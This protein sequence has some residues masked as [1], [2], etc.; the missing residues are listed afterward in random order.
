[1]AQNFRTLRASRKPLK[2]GDVFVMGLPDAMHLFG[3]VIS[4]S[5]RWT[6]AQDSGTT[7]LV[8]VFDHRSPDRAIPAREHLRA[9]RLLVPPQLV[10]RL[11]WNRGY[12]E[13]LGTLPFEDGET[14]DVHCFESRTFAAGP[15][16]F[17]DTARELPRPVPPVGV[18]GAGNHRTLEDAACEALGIPLAPDD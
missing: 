6:V 11:G 10:N 15:R 2:P 16:W 8:Y 9:D 18:W 1:M 12:F 3:R 14:L 13:T 5:A 17:D 7:N 4:T